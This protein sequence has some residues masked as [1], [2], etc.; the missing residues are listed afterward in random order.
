MACRR[1]SQVQ[2]FAYA[3]LV[4]VVCHDVP[5]DGYRLRHHVL[6]LA[7]VHVVQVEPDEFRPPA[8]R[9]DEPVLQHLGI[10]RAQVLLAVERL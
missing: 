10:S 6:Q 1:V 5:F 8:R 3:L 4:G 9:A 2:G 7:E